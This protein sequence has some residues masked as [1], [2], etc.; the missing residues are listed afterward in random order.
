MVTAA[1]TLAQCDIWWADL[2][3]PGGSEAGYHRPVV[4][5]QSDALNAS[6]HRT[7]ICVPLTS[8][9]DWRASPWNLFLSARST[10]LTKDALAQAALTLTIDRDRLIERIGRVSS[11]QLTRL[12]GCLDIALGR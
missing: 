2:G 1:A 7:V 11:V 6:R 8:N 9:T 12:F 4:I 10:G 5:V 3:E